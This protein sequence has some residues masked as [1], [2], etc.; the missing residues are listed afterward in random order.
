MTPDLDRLEGLMRTPISWTR[1][2]RDDLTLLAIAELRAARLA[3]LERPVVTDENISLRLAVVALADA[4]EIASE[5]FNIVQPY[6]S[7]YTKHGH[8]IAAARAALQVR[9]SSAKTGDDSASGGQPVEAPALDEAALVE[10][11]AKAIYAGPTYEFD[12]AD[13]SDARRDAKVALAAIDLPTLIAQACRDGAEGMR[14]QCS[15]A[16]TSA[17]RAVRALPLEPQA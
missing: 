5:R 10:K 17:Y 11:M 7:I 2:E 9:A 12:N 16:I 14:S 6:L 1:V 8:T 15:N 4:A 13:L 3:A